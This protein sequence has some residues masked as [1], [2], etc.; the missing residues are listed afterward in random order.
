[1]KAA[2][3]RAAGYVAPNTFETET[4][5]CI[6]CGAPLESWQHSRCQKCIDKSL[7]GVVATNSQ[8]WFDEDAAEAVLATCA[9][10]KCRQ[11]DTDFL[12][13]EDE[14]TVA[15]QTCGEIYDISPEARLENWSDRYA[16]AHPSALM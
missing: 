15:C 12:L 8:Q 13:L 4:R 1:M 14:N 11:R 5:T 3:S 9:C 6:E 2:L 7:A 16:L 10:P